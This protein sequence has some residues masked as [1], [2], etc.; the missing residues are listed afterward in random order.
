MTGIILK[1][2]L[3]KIDYDIKSLIRYTQVRQEKLSIESEIAKVRQQYDE[4]KLLYE[5]LNS[6]KSPADYSILY[7]QEN[8]KHISH[9]FLNLHSPQE[10][11]SLGM[12]ETGEIFGLRKN[13]KV[14]IN[15][16]SAGQRTALV[17]SV[18][19]IAFIKCNCTS[20]SFN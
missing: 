18:F 20:Y 5:K 1:A 15:S 14:S 10:F 6:L 7:I 19:S 16:M 11:S 3:D 12:D 4:Y 9:I 2:H 8:I 17:L 13:K